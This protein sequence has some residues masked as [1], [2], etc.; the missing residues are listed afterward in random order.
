MLPTRLLTRVKKL[1]SLPLKKISKKERNILAQSAGFDRST[2]LA[3]G[4]F[5][6]TEAIP[7][8]ADSLAP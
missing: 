3:I 1:S 4:A 2:I 8:K 6:F 7:F 5:F